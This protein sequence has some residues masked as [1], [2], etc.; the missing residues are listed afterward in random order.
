MSKARQLGAKHAP[1]E[2]FAALGDS[3]RLQ[4]VDRLGRGEHRSIAALS[5]G[6][7]LSR[8]GI[9]K[10]LRVLENAGII[11]SRRVG[12]EI[13]FALKPE[14]L[15]SLQDYLKL[16]SSQWDEAIERLQVFVE[17]K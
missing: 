9:T 11:E 15:T 12:R 2:L 13:Q 16:V 3:T 5:E 17:E 7:G 4:L 14:P 10:H 6:I 8:Q 1:A